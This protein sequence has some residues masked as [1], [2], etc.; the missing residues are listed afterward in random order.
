MSN[1]GLKQQKQQLKRREEPTSKLTTLSPALLILHSLKICPVML[2]G[3]FNLSSVYV[4]SG[5]DDGTRFV[6][7]ESQLSFR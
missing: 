1:L 4:T 7:L 2:S 3:D 6:S 5:S